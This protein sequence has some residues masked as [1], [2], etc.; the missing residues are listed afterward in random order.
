M[1][2]KKTFSSIL[3][4]LDNYGTGIK[5]NVHGDSTHNTIC[6]AILTFFTY[7]VVGGYGGFIGFNMFTFGNTTFTQ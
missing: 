7:L 3:S 1:T 6:G 4:K 5:F 2:K